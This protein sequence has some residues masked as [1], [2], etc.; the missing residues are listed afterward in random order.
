MARQIID[1]AMQVDTSWRSSGLVQIGHEFGLYA[2]DEI[3]L[4]DALSLNPGIHASLFNTQ[5]KSY[6]ALEPRM[7]AKWAFAQG[8]STKAAYSRMSQYVHLLSSSQMS[9]PIDLWVP[10]TRNIAPEVS[11]Q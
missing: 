4:S 2:E 9:L 3:Q 8:W 6:W 5:G 10:I 7:S 1:A 11:N